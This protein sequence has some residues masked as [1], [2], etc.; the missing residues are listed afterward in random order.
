[1]RFL[2]RFIYATIALGLL[3]APGCLFSDDAPADVD[4]ANPAPELGVALSEGFETGAKTSYSAAAVTL[5]SGT[6]MLDDTLIGNSASDIKAGAKAARARNSGRVTMRFDRTAGAST[7]TV[8]HAAYGADSNGSWGL[9]APTNQGVTWVQVGAATSTAGHTLS[10][11]TFTVNLAGAI[12]FEI[13]KLDGGTNR[14]N[15]DDI[16]ISDF[17][18]GGGGTGAGISRHTALGLPAAASTADVDSY[19]SVKSGYVISYNSSL[20]VPNWVSWEL[21]SSYIGSA[22]RVDTFRA[23]DTLPTSLPQASLADYV[24]SGYDRGHMTPS[25]DRTLTPAANSQT[26]YLSNMVP[27]SANNNRGAWATLE[28]YLRTLAASGKELFIVSGGTFSASSNWIGSGVMVPDQTFKVIVVLDSATQGAANVTNVS[29]VI[30]VLMPNEDVQI[31]S[32][33]DWHNY[34]V[35]V[36]TIEAQTGDDFLSDVAP[37]VQAIVEARIDTLP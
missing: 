17:G 1:M 3:G 23:D 13:R 2:P 5:G 21:N 20:K 34:R 16:T 25:A 4:G 10:T 15:F 30:S 27:Q 31:P 12:R 22:P 8:R 33:A 9:F 32:G 28:N 14:I 29:R 19:L 7:V 35:S 37:A 36:D 24:G 11:A 6:W 26:F 18:G